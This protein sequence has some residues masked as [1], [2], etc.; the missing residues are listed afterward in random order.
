MTARY[1]AIVLAGGR[2]S[3]LCGG[4]KTAVRIGGAAILDRVL[5]ALA[6]AA[7]TLVVGPPRE[8][9]RAVTWV[10]EDPPYAGPAYAVAAAL[11][12]VTRATVVVVAGDL[13]FLTPPAVDALVDALA[14]GQ[15]DGALA[16]DDRGEPQ[17][18]CGAWRAGAL[19]RAVAEVAVVPGTSMRALL[20]PLS[21]EP[22]V[23]PAAGAP[24]W[25][26]CDTAEDLARARSWAE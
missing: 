12:L 17:L 5:T 24:A 1:D 8:V 21:A 2:S 10:R 4:D 18:L 19:R 26:D 22:V 7:T 3:R 20:A 16:H 9:S 23:L 6:G 14:R 11:P 25:F 13:P 15:A